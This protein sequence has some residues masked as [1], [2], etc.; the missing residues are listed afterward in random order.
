MAAD[1]APLSAFASFI[2]T[3]EK[4]EPKIWMHIKH[5]LNS[6]KAITI[7]EAQNMYGSDAAAS[8]AENL[9]KWCQWLA[10]WIFFWR[11]VVPNSFERLCKT[12]K[13]FHT[14][15][16]WTINRTKRILYLCHQNLLQI[17]NVDQELS[18]L[19]IKLTT[20]RRKLFSD[21]FPSKMIRFLGLFSFTYS[22]CTSVRG[23][24]VIANGLRYRQNLK[25]FVEEFYCGYKWV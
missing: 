11:I 7:Q 23:N 21:P 20:L 13:I 3:L 19:I 5:C 18:L 4:S 15:F 1:A 8:D 24:D 12:F 9:C 6:A 2:L 14:H 10:S 16:I 22:R 25:K 17:W